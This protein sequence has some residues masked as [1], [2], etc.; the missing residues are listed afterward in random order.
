M[1]GAI[2]YPASVML[3]AKDLRE[4][5]WS[6]R[7]IQ[8]LLKEETGF[9]PTDHTILYWTDPDFRRRD[10]ARRRRRRSPRTVPGR[11]G[12]PLA[13]EDQKL[14]RMQALRQHNLSFRSIAEVMALDFGDQISEEQVR[15]A[16]TNGRYP[17]AC[18]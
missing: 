16:L 7:G 9:A 2:S 4:G 3:R 18:S 13:S 10:L 12:S 1:S 14:E 5:G 15:Y 6:L 8:Q 17:R 11:L